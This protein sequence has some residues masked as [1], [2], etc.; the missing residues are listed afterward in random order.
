MSRQTV[1]LIC[2][3]H[4]FKLGSAC[5]ECEA[6][7]SRETIHINTYDWIKE[8]TWEHIDP[9]NPNLKF[10]SKEELQDYCRKMSTSE[11][12]LI[13]KAFLKPKSQGKGYEMAKR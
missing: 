6:V 10:N 11:R 2:P 4:G 5:S 13:P 7:K 12:D 8:G 3:K 1:A 9:R